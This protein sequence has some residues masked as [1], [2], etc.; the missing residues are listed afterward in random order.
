MFCYYIMS[1]PAP[2]TEPTPATA[3][4]P[5][6]ATTEPKY[7]LGKY[8]NIYSPAAKNLYKENAILEKPDEPTY[9][10]ATLEE[11]DDNGYHFKINYG[12]DITPAEFKYKNILNIGD[13]TP[14]IITP[15]QIKDGTFKIEKS[16]YNGGKKSRA[17]K[18]TRK[19]KRNRKSKRYNR[20]R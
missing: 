7:E 6:T 15:K 14:L 3:T 12:S 18:N 9:R 17:K 5:T 19:S 13:G 11:I 20:R 10:P 2:A 16:K 1:E 4:E 8:Y